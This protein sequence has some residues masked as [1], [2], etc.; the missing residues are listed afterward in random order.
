MAVSSGE[1]KCAILEKLLT[2]CFRFHYKKICQ[3]TQMLV[4]HVRYVIMSQ[5]KINYS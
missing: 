1:M 4:R 5:Y 3:E 2:G